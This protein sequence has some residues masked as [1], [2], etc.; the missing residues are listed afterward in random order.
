[1]APPKL[2]PPVTNRSRAGARGEVGDG[3]QVERAEVDVVG[4]PPPDAQHA[5]P[6]AGRRQLLAEPVVE[7]VGRTEQ[8]AHGAAAEHHRRLGVRIAVPEHGEQPAHR[9][10]LEVAVGRR[11]HDLLAGERLEQVERAGHAAYRAAESVLITASTSIST[12]HCGSR[13][14]ATTTVV[15]AGRTSL[16]TSPCTPP[17]GGEVGRVDEVHAAAHDVGERGAGVLEGGADDLEAAP[18]LRRR[19]RVDACRRATAARCRPPR[20]APPPGSPGCTRP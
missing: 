1:M 2:C 18:G 17:I 7:A 19:V 15:L 4:T 13:R 6:A 20:P 12:F 14:A 11:D 16:N 9:E 8:P 10:H 5:D 3:Q